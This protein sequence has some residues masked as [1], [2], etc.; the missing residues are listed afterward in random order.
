M[1]PVWPVISISTLVLNLI[2][3]Y[4]ILTRR[5]TTA[6]HIVVRVGHLLLVGAAIYMLLPFFAEKSIASNVIRYLVNISFFLP[7]LY[8]FSESFSQKLFLFFLDW[9]FTTFLS[10][11]CVWI[12]E[13]I[14]LGR[15]EYAAILLLY[16][17][18]LCVVIPLYIKYWWKRIQKMLYFFEYGNHVYAILP[19]MNFVLFALLFGPLVQ[20]G[21]AY[22]FGVMLLFEFLV[23][24]TYNLLFSHFFVVYDQIR[25]LDN[26]R[27]AERQLDLQKKYYGEVDRG[28]RLQ[29]KRLQD[30]S[31]HLA[32]ISAL[33]KAGEFASIGRYI[34]QL[35]DSYEFQHA[36]R[37]CE[38]SVANAIIS[39]YI[40]IAEKDGI[41]VSVELDL[42]QDIGIDD[43]EL[44]TLFGNT[45]ENAIEAC[46]RIEADS[47]LH[48]GRFIGV[49]SKA[50]KGHLVVRIENSFNGK[51]KP[52]GEPFSSSKGAFGGVGLESVRT[53][54]ERYQ[55]CLNCETRDNVFI[56][57]AVL[58]LRPLARNPAISIGSAV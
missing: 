28:L 23:L 31:N 38:N 48:S 29:R 25:S 39:G 9:G 6:E 27:S 41:A 17:S 1:F 47:E 33:A 52:A 55:G 46:Q 42:P 8:L 51:R 13:F 19:L 12:A 32:E 58:C 7:C 22:W 54:V 3:E 26:F 4:A 16:F 44:C 15:I 34:D 57:S 20:P 5:R 11:F 49:K 21:E 50:E 53:V 10:S 35:M 56:F 24:F 45:I 2:M 40:E 14:D 43:Y 18:I 36:R 30:I 37:Y